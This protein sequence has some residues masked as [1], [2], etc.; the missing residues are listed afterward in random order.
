SRVNGGMKI[1]GL[2]RPKVQLIAYDRV[3]IVPKMISLAELN[4]NFSD[5][6]NTLVSITDKIFYNAG[7]GEKYSGSKVFSN[8]S[9]QNITLITETN[10]SFSNTVIPSSGR[11]TG[12]ASAA[13]SGGTN[14]VAGLRMRFISDMLIPGALYTNFPE[15]AETIN[16]SKTGYLPA[17][18]RIF[19]T[20]SWLLDNAVRQTSAQDIKNGSAAFRFPG[21][22]TVPCYLAMDF[23]VPN[24]ASKVEFKYANWQTALGGGTLQLEYSINNG[25][26]WIKAGPDIVVNNN[27]LQTASFTLDIDVPVRFRIKKLALGSVAIND[28]T[29]IDDISIFSN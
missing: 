18:S 17:Q 2:K 1:T 28:R 13:N 3:P 25:S 23:N 24:G 26:S 15:G 27:V 12:I 11:V 29:N 10:A 8:A 22:N 6:E 9:G 5:Y 16:S 21:G 4:S 20:G 7:A 19:R 14:I